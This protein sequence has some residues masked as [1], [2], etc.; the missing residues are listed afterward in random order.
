LAN[1]IVSYDLNGSVPSHAT[2]DKH[3]ETAGWSR[4]RILETVWWVG[5]EH[6]LSDVYDHVISILSDDDQIIVIEALEAQWDNLLIQDASLVEAW[7][8][9]H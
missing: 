7:R 3:I 9:N 2:M 4:G 5:T 6:S 1:Y 8:S